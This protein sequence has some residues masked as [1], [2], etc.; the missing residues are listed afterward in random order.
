[1]KFFCDL[2][3]FDEIEWIEI[4]WF[5]FFWFWDHDASWHTQDNCTKIESIIFN[6]NELHWAQS[7]SVW[8]ECLKGNNWVS[9]CVT[10]V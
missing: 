6:C 9:E 7:Q 1:M 10:N 4:A 8:W 2:Q 3:H 5:E